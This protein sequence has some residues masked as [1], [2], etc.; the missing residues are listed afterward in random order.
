MAAMPHEV[1][2]KTLQGGVLTVE[3]MPANTI[4]ELKAMLHE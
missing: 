3:V 1:K 2:V 4:E